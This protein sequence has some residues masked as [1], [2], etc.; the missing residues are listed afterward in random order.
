M[1]GRQGARL[2]DHA[3]IAPG[4]MSW[5]VLEGQLLEVERRRTSAS[6]SDG[7]PNPVTCAVV[8]GADLSAFHVGDEVTMKCKLTASGFRL[9]LLEV[10]PPRTTS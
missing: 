7:H 10:G 1:P 9:K 3:S 2:G 4:G 8:P 6:T 5:F